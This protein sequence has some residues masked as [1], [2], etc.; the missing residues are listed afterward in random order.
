[1]EYWHSTKKSEILKKLGVKKDK[2]LS[3]DEV[4]SR[5]LKNGFNEL[6]KE[7]PHTLVSIYLKQFLIPLI[8][9]LMVAALLSFI[10][11]EYLE[12]GFIMFVVIVNA[13]LGAYQE[14]SAEKKANAL[15]NLIKDKVKVKRNGKAM[16]IE[17]EQLVVGDIVLFEAGDKIAADLRILD[18]Y[19]L[20][21]DEAF[22]TGESI[23]IVKN[24]KEVDE[25]APLN[26]RKNMAYAGSTVVSGRGVGVV[27][28]TA[29]NTEVGKI[30]EK[31]IYAKNEKPPLVQRMET[32][33]KQIS[34]IIFIIIGIMGT[35][36][37][38]NGTTLIEIFPF[39]ITLAVSA[40]PE[41]LPIAVTVVLSIA[42]VR[43]AKKNV[44]VRKLNAVES[45][46]SCTVIASDKT[47]TLTVNEQTIKKLVFPNN[48][49]YD[50]SGVGYNG[51][52]E[53]FKEDVKIAKKESKNHLDEL[54]ITSML[55][56]EA[57]LYKDENEECY[58]YFGDAMDVAF[59]SLGLKQGYSKEELLKEVKLYGIIPYASENR[60]SAAFYE[61]EGKTF[62]G[63]K[64]AP[65]TILNHCDAMFEGSKEKPL[66]KD[67][68]LKQAKEMASDGYRVL[69]VAKRNVSF[70]KKKEY[71]E[72]DLQKLTFV[73]LVGFVDPLREEVIDSVN[74][75]RKAGIKVFMVTGD[76]KET[77]TNI[78]KQLNL[79]T[80]SK[81]VADGTELEE[82][83]NKGDDHF[84]KLVLKSKV[85]ARVSPH[86]KQKIVNVL[87]ENGEF[88]AVTGDGV[89]DAPAL[90][91]SNIGVAMGSG[92]DI[93]M[94]TSSMIITD[95][96]FMSIVS[97]VEEGRFAYDNI[98][99]VTYL[100]ISTA[101]A[102]LLIFSAAVFIGSPLPLLPAQILWLNFVTNGILDIA[103]AFEPGEKE[104]MRRKPRDPEET[105]FNREMIVQTLVSGV[106]MASI[107]FGLWL[108]FY[109]FMGFGVYE[110]R[111]LILLLLVIMENVHVFNC[112]SERKSAFK[113]PFFQ[114]K[115]L[116]YALAAQVVIQ[117]FA[118]Y[119]PFMQQILHIP[120]VS[121]DKLLFLIGSAMPLIFV[122][123]IYKF[124]KRKIHGYN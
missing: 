109:D 91:S 16:V 87:K 83:L 34:V 40:I 14:W 100:L 94:Q 57:E 101:I 117:V 65:E 68:I 56:N 74:K 8:M 73:G 47:G 33:T 37:F 99:K 38:I 96:N 113:I 112:R 36:L 106:L 17:S 120:T 69:A 79:I 78:A 121:F 9:I 97:G 105:I 61:S 4:Q 107:A 92:T 111:G 118:M 123:E 53:V 2:G 76:Q 124:F 104:A 32:F 75:C 108:Y 81:R 85:F 70:D 43:M 45:L 119:T 3:N 22:L 26:D 18:T 30:A 31:I 84:K 59:L 13:C 52:G 11:G 15:Q 41:S 80:S 66:K 44:I 35:Y 7:K 67:K 6:P 10:I 55:A 90:R 116:I 42:T 64:G 95:D 60:Y 102:E 86:Q 62:I 110:S 103:L 63:M 21:I 114:N 72:D 5:L 115:V 88:I 25:E 49:I 50:I 29:L 28:E 77:A 12:A 39:A 23:A 51:G 48:D 19:Q 1:M 20:S 24:D 89:N 122:M 93:A 82:A 54:I 71:V 58:K 46:G 27:V 98:R